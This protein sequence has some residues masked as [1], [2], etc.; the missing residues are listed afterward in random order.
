MR[1][2]TAIL[3]VLLL[4]SLL[5]AGCGQEKNVTGSK[6]SSEINISSDKAAKADTSVAAP[7]EGFEQ[8]DKT[9]DAD[10]ALMQVNM[11]VPVVCKLSEKDIPAV[12]ALTGNISIRIDAVEEQTETTLP[13]GEDN[14]KTTNQIVLT[15]NGQELTATLAQNSSAEALKELLEEGPLTISMHDYGSMEKV[16]DIGTS[17]PTNDEQI[18]TE[19]GDLILYMSSAFVIYYVPN[20]WSFTRLGKIDNITAQELKDILGN[21]NVEVTISLPM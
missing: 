5:L 15:I 7:S 17:L 16:G 9:S 13:E 4:M 11:T 2:T 21:G 19:A 3:C 10:T 8:T 12:T 18:T 1:K 14:M 6:D 20:S